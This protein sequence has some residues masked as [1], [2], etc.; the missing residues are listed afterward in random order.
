MY[1]NS[2]TDIDLE[3]FVSRYGHLLAGGYADGYAGS[4]DA[5]E[6]SG[7][8]S[9][10]AFSAWEGDYAEEDVKA[11]LRLTDGR[12]A[13]L[14]ASCD[15]SGYDCIGYVDW[16]YYERFE[17]AVMFGLDDNARKTLFPEDYDES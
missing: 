5:P 12:Y 15:T 11:L 16:N 9:V 1:G 6:A 10:E 17:D 13:T 2:T 4:G 3:T 14:T 8:A 7:L